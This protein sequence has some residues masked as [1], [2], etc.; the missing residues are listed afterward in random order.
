LI[1]QSN[2]TFR[3]A[4]RRGSDA[5]L[6]QRTSVDG[7]TWSAE[8]V[9]NAASSS[10]PSLIQQT[11]GTFRVAYR[12]D[13]DNCLVQRTSIDGITWS[14]VTVINASSSGY[15]S[16]IQQIDKSLMIIYLSSLNI[17]IKKSYDNGATWTPNVEFIVATV[18]EQMSLIQEKNTGL[19]VI[20][21]NRTMFFLSTKPI[22]VTGHA[23]TPCKIRYNGPAL[24]PTIVKSATEYLRIKRTINTG[25]YFEVNTEL[26]KKTIRLVENGVVK[27]GM[28]YLDLGSTL[29]DLDIGENKL[30]YETDDA[31]QTATATI[32]WTER[33]IGC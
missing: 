12:R 1:Q 3:I 25:D 14:A 4:Y 24:N 19:P 15:S 17:Y 2:G 30:F 8:T 10:F 11:D 31:A 16:L 18:A 23:N 20:A 9:I 6:V 28:A 32:E 29:F 21:A 7:A 5:S 13:S 22:Q 33:Y 26:G 27:N